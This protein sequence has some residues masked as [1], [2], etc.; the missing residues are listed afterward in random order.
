[1]TGASFERYGLTSN[2]FRDL[3]SESLDDVEIF[4]VNLQV[5]ET[6]RTIKD[7]V[8]EKENRA[9]VAISGSHGAGKTERLLLAASEGRQRKAFV[10]YY[11]ITAKTSWILKGLAEQFLAAVKESGRA[12]TFTTP[13]WQRDLSSL[14]GTKDHAYDAVAAGKAIAAALNENAPSLLL[15]NDLHHLTAPGEVDAFLRTLQEVADAIR[16]GVLVMFGCYP[17]YLEAVSKNRA[18]FASRLNRTFHLPSLS[19]DEAALL[20]A[21]KLLAKRLVEDLDPLYPFDQETIAFLN[22]ASLGNPRRLLELADLAIAFGV[23]HRSYRVDI[24]VARSALAAAKT[25]AG[26]TSSSPASQGPPLTPSIS[27]P[28]LGA[29]SAKRLPGATLSMEK[30]SPQ[31]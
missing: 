13:R 2:P 12:K 18:A 16:P 19:V 17:P 9:F 5:D 3:A 1:M 25:V 11:D 24:D 29:P 20:L 21:K 8:F 23:E 27:A 6:L 7:E 28:T 10:V 30:G 4:H 26:P 14:Q 31:S 15:L 22:E